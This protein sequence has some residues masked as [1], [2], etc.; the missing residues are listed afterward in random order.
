MRIFG[1]LG[2]ITFALTGCAVNSNSRP[3]D[4]YGDFIPESAVTALREMLVIDSVKQL[5]A[6][7]PPASTRFD[8]SQSTGDLYGAKLVQSLRQSGYAL[9]ESASPSTG[10]GLSLR[11]IVDSP[12]ENL[13]RVTLQLG[14]KS[15]S[16]AYVTQNEKISP[17]GA[18]VR[19]E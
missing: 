14:T 18:W 3:P 6:L 12:E 10:Q 2:L 17:A 8:L 15:L 16:R 19:G 4:A 5:L 11:Y 13:Y 9:S 7:Y 1:L